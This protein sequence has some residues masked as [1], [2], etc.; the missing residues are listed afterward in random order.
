MVINTD[1]PKAVAIFW[2]SPLMLFSSS[3]LCLILWGLFFNRLIVIE[4]VEAFL[5]CI[6]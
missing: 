2:E 5:L 4:K 1:L 6:K 3:V